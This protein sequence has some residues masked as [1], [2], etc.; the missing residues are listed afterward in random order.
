MPEI[1]WNGAQM[2][3]ERKGT[4]T[5]VLMLHAMSVSGSYWNKVI[6]NI[7]ADHSLLLPDL[8]YHGQSSDWP[9]ST[10][11]TH[12]DNAE[13][14]R[15]LLETEGQTS[16]HLVGHSYGG[17]AAVAFALQF[18]EI[19]D[20]LVLIEPSLPTLIFETSDTDLIAAHVKMSEQFDLHIEAGEPDKGWAVYIDARGGPGTW[21]KMP[22]DRKQKILATTKQAYAVGKAI[23]GNPLK[24]DDLHDLPHETLMI[25][26][27][28]TA[29]RDRRTA[30][31][32][33]ENIPNCRVTVIDG[34]SHM[35]PGSHPAE[36]AN[37]IESHLAAG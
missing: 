10:H 25:M 33:H 3:Y 32:V 14:M 9:H 30:E 7:K 1:S 21:D 19:V 4:G 20:R 36:I 11:L 24:L 2:H 12:R 5:P 16:V 35:S 27:G 26:G 18:P 15:T 31:L 22:E 17:A 13:M 8:V 28:E 29:P 34:A 6:D 37:A 23:M